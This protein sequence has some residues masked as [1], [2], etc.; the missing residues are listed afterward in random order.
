MSVDK[1]KDARILVNFLSGNSLE[2]IRDHFQLRSVTQVEAAVRRALAT[3]QKRAEKFPQAAIEVARID[4][5]YK[6]MHKKAIGGDAKAVETC[7]KLAAERAALV[8]EGEGAELLRAFEKTVAA[9][10][11]KPED[12]SVVENGRTVAKQ[13]DHTMKHGTP[14]ERTKALYLIPHLMNV[15]RE[16]GASPAARGELE[17]EGKRVERE[18]DPVHNPLAEL[19]AQMKKRM[20]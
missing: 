2:D 17:A 15:L 7:L 18:T 9:L 3:D 14:F 4:A 11:L 8:D 16:L 20:A 1:K 5:M 6:P 12:A 19:Q 10:T 13:I